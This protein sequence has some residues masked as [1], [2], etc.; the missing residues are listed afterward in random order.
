MNSDTTT[1]DVYGVKTACSFV[2]GG[3]LDGNCIPARDG[4]KR[5]SGLQQNLVILCLSAYRKQTFRG[6]EKGQPETP[7]ILP[8]GA[9]SGHCM[10]AEKRT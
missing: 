7:A 1:Y 10:A 8:L 2:V 4:L 9:N 5:G 3:Q 6:A